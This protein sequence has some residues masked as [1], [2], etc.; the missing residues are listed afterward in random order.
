[1]TAQQIL[2][3]LVEREIV[4]AQQ[5]CADFGSEESSFSYPS[6]VVSRTQSQ[7]AAESRD[8]PAKQYSGDRFSLPAAAG[9]AAAAANAA[10]AA[11]ATAAAST[12]SAA[13]GTATAAG[14]TGATAAV[15]PTATATA[16]SSS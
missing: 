16:G 9:T 8:L 15:F 7:A 14:S 10:E 4:A 5:S 6:A 13:G 1:M 3:E 11:A 2:A 12:A